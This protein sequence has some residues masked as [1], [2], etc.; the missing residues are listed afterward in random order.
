MWLHLFFS[1]HT[2]GARVP[3]PI[4]GALIDQNYYAGKIFGVSVHVT[5]HE[6]P[7]YAYADVEISGVPIGSNSIHGRAWYANQHQQGDVTID[8]ALKRALRRRGVALCDVTPAEDR[9]TIA[10][11]V[12]L[13]LIGKQGMLLQQYDDPN[14]PND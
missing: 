14:D 8:Y 6:T 1:K 3:A 11:T 5:L 13:P 12:D 9:S 2:T 7:P 10:V 4:M